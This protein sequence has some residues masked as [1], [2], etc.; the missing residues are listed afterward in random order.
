MILA[1]GA[2]VS[3]LAS[4]V[5]LDGEARNLW[6]GWNAVVGAKEWVFQKLSTATQLAPAGK[7]N[8]MLSLIGYPEEVSIA[9][10]FVFGD[11]FICA[12]V[13]TLKL[14]TFSALVGGGGACGAGRGGA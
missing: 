5:L 12:D 3:A 7:V 6:H 14:V 2:S 4:A 1:H 10:A 9:M 13:G 8:L 11:T